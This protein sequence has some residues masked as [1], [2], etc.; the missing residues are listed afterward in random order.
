MC[1]H[2]PSEH[3]QKDT[4]A[5]LEASALPPNVVGHPW[6]PLLES[7]G[8]RLLVHWMDPGV[9][10][11]CDGNVNISCYKINQMTRD[12]HKAIKRRHRDVK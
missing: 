1:C 4:G 2:L 12:R 5:G 7:K 8:D 3:F 10:P 9:G 11:P 6:Y